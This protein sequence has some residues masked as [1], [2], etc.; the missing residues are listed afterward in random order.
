MMMLHMTNA[1]HQ[2]PMKASSPSSYR[3]SVS[4][5]NHLNLNLENPFS[6]HLISVELETTDCTNQLTEFIPFRFSG[7]RSVR[8]AKAN[9]SKGPIV[10]AVDTIPVDKM[11]KDKT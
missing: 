4:K 7:S 10:L 6:R 3:E 11:W 2:Q 9:P 5:K 8:K 1:S